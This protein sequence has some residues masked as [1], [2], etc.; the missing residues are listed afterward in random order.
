VA[1]LKDNKG[2]NSLTFS[3]NALYNC[4]L[5]S[6]TWLDCLWPSLSLRSYN[7]YSCRYL[8]YYKA[9]LVKVVGVIVLDAILGFNI[10]Y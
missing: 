10:S 3:V 8:A 9:S 4:C 1:R 7:N 5:L 2:Q 6:I